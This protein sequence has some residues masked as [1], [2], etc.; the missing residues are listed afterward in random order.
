MLCTNIYI[1]TKAIG[2]IIR[3]LENT[4]KNSK[5]KINNKIN[6]KIEF[7]NYTYYII[8]VSR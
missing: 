8:I 2:N 4:N 6:N 5:T 1:R 3:Y 7:K